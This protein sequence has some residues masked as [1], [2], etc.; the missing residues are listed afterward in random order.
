MNHSM[1][2]AA[3]EFLS[4]DMEA[5]F[6]QFLA[7][8]YGLYI[9]AHQRDKF[10]QAVCQ[11]CQ[12][13][14][15]T[16]FEQFL[17]QLKTD[18]L[19]PERLWLIQQITVDESYFFRDE[20]QHQ[21]L[22]H[23]FFP[24]LIAQK[25][26][27]G[28]KHIR[29]W[30]AGCSTGQEIYTIAIVLHQLLPDFADWQLHLIASD[31]NHQSLKQAIQGEYNSWEIRSNQHF[32]NHSGY[33]VAQPNGNYQLHDLIKSQVKFFFLN[34][35][36][37]CFPSLMNQTCNLDLILCRNVF[38]YFQAPVIEQT[39]ARFCQALKPGGVLLLS[40]TDPM[41][42]TTPQLISRQ[43]GDV[44]Y[45]QRADEHF[46]FSYMTQPR[47]DSHVSAAVPAEPV[48]TPIE[49]I[50]DFWEL[51]KQIIA[52]LTANQWYQVLELCNAAAL[53]HPQNPELLQFKAKALVN[54][55]LLDEAK[56]ACEQ[57]IGSYDLDPHS[58]LLY[59]SI[60]L[61]LNL[62]TEAEK[63]FRQTIFL[64]YD[65]MEAHYQLGHVLLY[66]GQYAQA[67]KA[68][69]NAL[70]LAEQGD[71][72]RPVHNVIALTY[73]SFAETIRNE[74]SVLSKEPQA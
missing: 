45:F 37:D 39:C 15:W 43:S 57:S 9:H 24:H 51:K 44:F 74:L 26:Q 30:S 35:A 8:H 18:S 13:F 72:Q 31:I 64:N 62:Y 63:A 12:Q 60:L 40:A 23:E 41:N 33:F 11:T 54:L 19:C 14:H 25:R 20:N 50:A 65:F 48:P 55:G 42:L 38:I 71:A 7:D 6:K 32:V 22:R 36:E 66:K 10:R 61:Q 3:N 73:G 29:I 1:K 4:A 58:Y 53:H 46:D 70:H 21:F 56:E 68:I 5:E 34:L 52:L 59:G 17:A 69:K 28:D 2:T 27:H 67:L 49:P 16:D 47:F